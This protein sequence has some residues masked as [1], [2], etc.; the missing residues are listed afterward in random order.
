[1]GDYVE[2]V[3]D[4]SRIQFSMHTDEYDRY[5]GEVYGDDHPSFG[6]P[7]IAFLASQIEFFKEIGD[8]AEGIDEFYRDQADASG[9]DEYTVRACLNGSFEKVAIC[10]WDDMFLYFLGMAEEAGLELPWPCGVGEASRA[11]QG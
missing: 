4:V 10:R 11:V 6:M 9:V 5:I 1:M 3:Y 8:R 2:S 7:V